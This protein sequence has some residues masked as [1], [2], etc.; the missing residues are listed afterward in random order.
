[1]LVL[2]YSCNLS[3]IGCSKVEL[4]PFSLRAG[5]ICVLQI[6]HCSICFPG[7]VCTPLFSNS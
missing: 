1:M 7:I 2:W 4:V 3:A 6:S 5:E